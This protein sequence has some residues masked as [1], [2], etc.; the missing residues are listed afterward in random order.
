MQT[1]Y[2]DYVAQ[3]KARDGGAPTLTAS[4]RFEPYLLSPWQT[5]DGNW[6]GPGNP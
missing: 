3:L 4:R 5:P 1:E 6:P 2:L